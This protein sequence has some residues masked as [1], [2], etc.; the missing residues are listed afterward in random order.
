MTTCIKSCE[1]PRNT[2]DRINARA[3]TVGNHIAFNH[4]EYDPE[5][6]EGQRVIA[7]E[8]A[9][10]RQQTGGALSM[11]P[12]EDLQLEIDPDP[13]LEREAEE[14]AE[15]VMSGGE[16]D[17]Q[18]YPLCYTDVHVQRTEDGSGGGEGTTRREFMGL[19]DEEQQQ[20]REYVPLGEF[21]YEDSSEWI[22]SVREEIDNLKQRVT[23]LESDGGG[24]TAAAATAA[25]AGA[26]A[27]EVLKNIGQLGLQDVAEVASQ[28]ETG[29]PEV[30][31]PIKALAAAGATGTVFLGGKAL[32]SY[33]SA[34]KSAFSGE[35][36][37]SGNEYPGEE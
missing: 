20:E 30:D 9:H 21:D 28:V 25:S 2:S 26:A 31:I 7:H 15:R 22:S 5:S 12:Q 37:E 35:E 34:L 32:K 13:K 8:L 14:T 27:T 17:I 19:D 10:V 1:R 24:G 18:R 36:R 3:F 23:Q 11:L 4:G 29:N 16:L 33:V 6:A